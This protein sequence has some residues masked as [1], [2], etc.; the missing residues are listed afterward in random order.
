MKLN[1]GYSIAI[2]YT[3][4]ALSMILFAIKAS[5]QHY[6][7]VNDN[8]YEQAV[9]YQTKIDAENNASS[10][11]SKLIVNY[12]HENHSIEISTSDNKAMN[13]TLKFYKPDKASDDFAIDF[14]TD[15]SG[16]QLIP[17]KKLAYGNW[18]VSV[19]WTMNGKD[20]YEEKKLF[21]PKQ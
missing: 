5:K 14:K 12:L 6:D 21:I 11:S 8:Y 18:K 2:V 4:F 7:L 1:W 10:S 16:K 15:E 3:L 20:C 19:S 9:N 17:L 13:G